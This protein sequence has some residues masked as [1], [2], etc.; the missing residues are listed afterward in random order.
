MSFPSSVKTANKKTEK[1]KKSTMKTPNSI[2]EGEGHYSSINKGEQQTD[3]TLSCYGKFMISQKVIF[4]PLCRDYIS[5]FTGAGK[6]REQTL[7]EMTNILEKERLF[8]KCILP[9]RE[10]L[11]E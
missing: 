5:N 10:S 7:R 11:A 6:K 1:N 2:S 4:P 8:T 9:E 3:D